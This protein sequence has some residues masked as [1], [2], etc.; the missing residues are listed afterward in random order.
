[1]IHKEIT[2]DII[3]ASMEVLNELRPGLEEKLYERA[4][5]L[6]LQKRGHCIDQQKEF[7]VHYKGQYIG[8]L[9]PDMVVDAKVIADPKVVTVF[10]DTH[11]AQMLGY[12]SISG[13]TVAILLNFKYSKLEWK[14]VVN[15][16]NRHT[17]G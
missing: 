17:I 8:T 1:M 14:R 9:V 6:E 10:N 13:L 4:L 7:P 2:N 16:R 11:L 15:E 12:L 5:V 3:G